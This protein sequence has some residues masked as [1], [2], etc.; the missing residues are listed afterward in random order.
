[1][2]RDTAQELLSD[3][4]EGELSAEDTEALEALLEKDEVLRGELEDLRRTLATLSALPTVEPSDDFLQQVRQKIRRRGKSPFDLSFG[5]ERK[6]PFEAI[7]MVLIGLLL[8]LYLL[9]VVLP[10]ER[11]DEDSIAPPKRIQVD[12]GVKRTDSGVVPM[13]PRGTP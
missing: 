1:M 9:L 13:R 5:L 11:V 12:G 8:A 4:L 7:S 10:R 2:D 3:Y 6:I